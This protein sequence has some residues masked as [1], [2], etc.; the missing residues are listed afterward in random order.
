VDSVINKIDSASNKPILYG[1]NKY[2]NFGSSFK[3][4][5]VRVVDEFDVMLI[6]DACGGYFIEN[7]TTTGKGQ[8]SAY[9]NHIFD[10]KYLLDDG[11]HVSPTKILN[12]LKDIV[13]SVLDPRGSAPPIRDNQA[14]TAYIARTKTKIDL[15][16]APILKRTNDHK[17]FYVIP[18]GGQSNGWLSTSPE[19]DMAAVDNAAK[20]RDD[21]RN[22]IRI[23]KRIRDTYN[24]VNVSSFA[25]ETIV[26]DFVYHNSWYQNLYVDCRGTLSHL[27]GK[28]RSGSIPDPF[29]GN[30]LLQEA[31]QLSWYADRVRSIINTLDF[32]LT[33][34]NQNDMNQLVANAFE[35]K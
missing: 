13:W 28:F 14:I 10:S 20:N 32:C 30:N 21:F 17:T 26:I 31:N 25:I 24:F 7:G 35:N 6:I 8:G 2:I 16:P 1:P 27:S 4:T 12:W 3:K 11:R 33:L 34:D 15:V 5:K 22:V 9:P 29:S 23:C 19:D 18:K